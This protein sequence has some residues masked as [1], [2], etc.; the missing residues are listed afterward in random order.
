MPS[1]I[2]NFCLLYE[3]FACEGMRIRTALSGK[4]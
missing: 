2:T 3:R 1:G 4:M